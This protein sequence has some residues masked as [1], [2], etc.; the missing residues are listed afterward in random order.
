MDTKE[1]SEEGKIAMS[2]PTHSLQCVLCK[3]E[4]FFTAQSAILD[5]V[6]DLQQQFQPAETDGRNERKALGR[7]L[8]HRAV[9]VGHR[10]AP[11]SPP[12]A[13]G[14]SHVPASR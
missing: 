1:E 10:G 9:P 3:C 8:G 12:L 2:A 5:F 13:A 7:P 6:G 14:A 4:F 11:T